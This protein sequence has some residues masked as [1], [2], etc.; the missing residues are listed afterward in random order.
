MKKISS[1]L[2]AAC[3]IQ[4]SLF[5]T[6]HNAVS[7]EIMLPPQC[8]IKL[9]LGWSNNTVNT[10]IFRHHG[11]VTRGDYQITAYYDDQKRMVFVKRNIATGQTE[12]FSL[13]GEYNTRDAHNSISLGIDSDSFIHASYDH[14]GSPLHYRR[15]LRPM[16]ITAWSEPLSMTGTLE[17]RVTYPYFVM[18]PQDKNDHESKGEL[19]F[20]YRHGSSGNGDLCMKA[21]DVK[22]QTWTDRAMRFLKGMDQ[23]PWT[24]NAYWNH[25]A[26]DNKGNMH[27]SFVWRANRGGP[28]DLVNN[29]NI[30][31]ACTPDSGQTWLTSRGLPLP[32]PM[33]QVTSEVIWPIPPGSN[34]IN[35]CSSAIDNDGWLHIVYYA[36][37]IRGIPQYHHLWFDGQA[38]QCKAI[39]RRTD[40]FQLSGGGALRLPISR[41]E[42]VID[43]QNR[44]F[45]IY[46]G[47][48]SED[49][50]TAQQLDP[51]YYAPGKTLLLFDKNLD[52]AEPIIDRIRWERDGI[53]SMLIQK[54]HQPNHDRPEDVP[55][56]PVYIVDWDIAAE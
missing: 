39:S 21:Y 33:T 26:F 24:S 27:L 2:L 16:D 13:S 40:D 53:L 32:L 30:G 25:P 43:K 31:Y 42:I 35:Q 44:V 50:M 46:R 18:S 38:W 8:S 4:A 52:H 1:I 45:V 36:D 11:I 41:P 51:P 48:I 55:F 22:T 14:H 10:V 49:R 7:E 6:T 3:I 28:P 56:E 9:G 20:L 19:L 37:D 5:V 29:I 15:S 17:D 23:S 47:D 12:S 34:L 54:N